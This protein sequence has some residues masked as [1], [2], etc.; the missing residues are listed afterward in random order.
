[1]QQVRQSRTSDYLSR[2]I[3]RDNRRDRCQNIRAFQHHARSVKNACRFLS[4]SNIGFLLAEAE[5]ARAGLDGRFFAGR[6]LKAEL[7]DQAL[8]D[9]NDLSG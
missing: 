4:G 2:E 8:F 1:V 7:Y 5:K 6:T 3:R 9:H